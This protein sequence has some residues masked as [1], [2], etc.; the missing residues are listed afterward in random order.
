CDA[1]TIGP[2]VVYKL[3]PKTSGNY[4][5]TLDGLSANLDLLVIP[6][7]TYY[8]CTS[9]TTCGYSSTNTGTTSESVTIAADTS[10]VYFIAVDGKD[11]AVSPYH[12]KVS[13]P[14]CGA[15]VCQQGS[16]SLNCTTGAITSH[17]DGPGS[18]N[19]V[20][21][22]SCDANTTGPEYATMFTPPKPGTYT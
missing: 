9:G 4:T 20:G 21:S 3:T 22:W 18:T 16:L 12:I 8:S 10:H 2:E 14:S 5:V 7:L 15:A 6:E 1:N 13:S 17:N 19:D 11:G